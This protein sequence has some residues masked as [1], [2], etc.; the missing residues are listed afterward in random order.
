MERYHTGIKNTEKSKKHRVIAIYILRPNTQYPTPKITTE[1][2]RYGRFL[3]TGQAE[4]TE[5]KLTEKYG[6][7]GL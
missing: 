7:I 5:L 6:K 1:T 2:P 4:S 3:P